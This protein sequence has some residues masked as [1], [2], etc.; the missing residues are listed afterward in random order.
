MNK[1]Q[2]TAVIMASSMLFACSQKLPDGQTN[3]SVPATSL[4]PVKK[5]MATAPLPVAVASTPID[6]YRPISGGTDIVYLYYA[7]TGLPIPYEDLAPRISD[8][9]RNTQD[10]FKKKEVLDAL[11]LKI[12]ANVE[13]FKKT[14]YISF[15]EDGLLGHYDLNKK[16]FIVRGMPDQNDSKYT[17]FGMYSVSFTNV[18]KFSGYKVDEVERAKEIEALVTKG[19]GVAVEKIELHGNLYAFVQKANT[20]TKQIQ[21]QIVRIQAQDEA[22]KVP[23]DMRM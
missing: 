1:L 6:Q 20:D 18:S 4:E 15:V 10:A 2:T 22:G 23:V 13:A 16:S 17:S 14:D 5:A 9:Y 7:K 11:K 19:G 21:V 3:T 12:D 8:E